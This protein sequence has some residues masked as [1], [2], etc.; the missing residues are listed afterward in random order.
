MITRPKLDKGNVKTLESRG[1]ITFIFSFDLNGNVKKCDI[2]LPEL[3]FIGK[4]IDQATK[5]EER[6]VKYGDTKD[7]PLISSGR[8]VD[9]F[10]NANV[11][12]NPSVEIPNKRL[13]RY[14]ILKKDAQRVDAYLESNSMFG[15]M[16]VDYDVYSDLQKN[17]DFIQV[18]E[19][20]SL[21]RNSKDEE[22]YSKSWERFII[23]TYIIAMTHLTPKG[24]DKITFFSSSIINEKNID[25]NSRQSRE[26]GLGGLILYELQDRTAPPTVEKKVKVVDGRKKESIVRTFD[27]SYYE[28]KNRLLE[29]RNEFL[30]RMANL[31]FYKVSI[32]EHVN[33]NFRKRASL[34]AI[35]AIISRNG[36]HGI[37]SHVLPQVA[38]SARNPRDYQILL[39][40][41]QQRFD[42]IAQVS[43]EFPKW[44]F[45]AW[46][47]GDLMMRFYS[48]R[49][50]LGTLVKA[51]GIE[52]F[53]FDRE[54]VLEKNWL[55]PEKVKDPESGELPSFEYGI[56]ERKIIGRTN[57]E[58]HLKLF[59]NVPKKR[60][61]LDG[62]VHSIQLE[63]KGLGFS[64]FDPA[65][66]YPLEDVKEIKIILR[67][68][69]KKNQDELTDIGI[70]RFSKEDF[71]KG[72]GT[73]AKASFKEILTRMVNKN[74]QVRV[75][76][77]EE[78]YDSIIGKLTMKNCQLIHGKL[79]IKMR[80]RSFI[81][82][83]N[84]SGK[85]FKDLPRVSVPELPT[86]YYDLGKDEKIEKALEATHGAG[87]PNREL[88]FYGVLCTE[89]I[90]K[91]EIG[92]L[93][94]YKEDYNEKIKYE[95]YND[96]LPHVCIKLKNKHKDE[97]I[98]NPEIRKAL[99][100]KGRRIFVTGKIVKK[101]GKKIEIHN[102]EIKYIVWTDYVVGDG[103]DIEN[104][105]VLYMDT[106]VAIP[107]GVVGYQAVYTILENLIRNAAKH[108]WRNLPVEYRFGRNLEV[109]VELEDRAKKDYLICKVWTN[110]HN[111]L[112][113][114]QNDKDDKECHTAKMILNPP[115]AQ[116]LKNLGTSLPLNSGTNFKLSQSILNKDKDSDRGRFNPTDLGIT[117]KRI[118]AG[119]LNM[120]EPEVIAGL[121]VG[122]EEVVLGEVPDG[123]DKGFIKA[124]SV[125][126]ADGNTLIPRFGY[127]IKLK[128]P[129][130]LLVLYRGKH[131]PFPDMAEKISQ[132][133]WNPGIS[134]DYEIC[135]LWMTDSAVYQKLND[136]S[137]LFS[138]LKELI[139]GKKVDELISRELEKFPFRLFCVVD[140]VKKVYGTLKNKF[141]KKRIF[142]ISSNELEDV[143]CPE[144]LKIL[145]QTL[146]MNF[147]NPAS[148]SSLGSTNYN[149]HVN[150]G[151]KEGGYKRNLQTDNSVVYGTYAIF[152]KFIIQ[153]YISEDG[154]YSFSDLRFEPSD[155]S[156]P[157]IFPFLK[158][159]IILEYKSAD[160]KLKFS[161]LQGIFKNY[162]EI[163]KAMYSKTTDLVE[164]L[165]VVYRPESTMEKNMFEASDSNSWS[166][167]FNTVNG[168]YISDFNIS[169]D[170]NTGTRVIYERHNQNK[171][172]TGVL[173]QD[174][175][176][177]GQ[178]F[179]SL[180]KEHPQ[181]NDYAKRK[182]I[183]QL[184][185]NAMMR[186]L[187]LDE[188]VFN[189]VY[190]NNYVRRLANVNVFIPNQVEVKKQND[191]LQQLLE[192]KNKSLQ[193]NFSGSPL[194]VERM[195]I[196]LDHNSMNE[197]D[198]ANNKFNCIIIHQSLL[199]EAFGE[200][201]HENEDNEI[202]ETR[203]DRIDNFIFELKQHIPSVIITSGKGRP[204]D[205][206]SHAKF[207]PFS[208][209][210]G[211]IMKEYPEKFLLT[212]MIF[213]ALNK[214]NN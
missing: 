143:E 108:D 75:I 122:K 145:L 27:F 34:A 98:H 2:F 66:N 24:K 141:I 168:N 1:T 17:P 172:S 161:R 33:L 154:K 18:C 191:D 48:Q 201:N 120:V 35:A 63:M 80:R 9:I 26:R 198:R 59:S 180:L 56:E 30:S 131:L 204:A 152:K 185:E 76:G 74:R 200:G 69:Y 151:L 183:L 65:L 132:E 126:E 90:E 107:G 153:N 189:F 121:M 8:I 84:L 128:K 68:S 207:L 102:A 72:A 115:D 93:S 117:E 105:D 28:F 134:L 11:R 116:D 13:K 188:R 100:K 150:L 175:L 211:F 186:V 202:K 91:G 138:L 22:P 109:K 94:S 73:G 42:F 199:N 187:I 7:T 190:E 64:E 142:F 82:F 176:S 139:D 83:N 61:V 57:I 197:E 166:S 96:P 58:K 170:G 50:L 15:K 140:D 45:P 193:L 144:K 49:L 209:I 103:H 112:R 46:F 210:E 205:M 194:I 146:W 155:L 212:Q 12:I 157:N 14:T 3:Y 44:T 95:D 169:S 89:D 148:K 159:W 147:L 23:G 171:K 129:K 6:L 38:H 32:T 77:M 55:K 195:K 101:G 123:I 25:N 174:Y 41:I 81:D 178:I 182:L 113:K 173:Y 167:L 99:L 136:Q 37:G 5:K 87:R 20:L 181:D 29:Y 149:L 208:N 130:E 62:F 163:Y 162:M 119:Y 213:K 10:K 71:F 137:D 156:A 53:E 160:W 88:I 67:R 179:Y 79:V 165:P 60:L 133:K 124:T 206:S 118:A 54:H 184:L 16:K 127:K 97:I 104:S 196:Y 43:S 158:S 164:T 177:G 19:Y 114:N 111:M 51:E 4:G 21:S 39:S 135:L 40:Y 36:S 52:A 125:W 110:A 70:C 86:G 106:Q 47:N 203:Q 92:I 31:L 85:K 192:L 78:K 214:Y